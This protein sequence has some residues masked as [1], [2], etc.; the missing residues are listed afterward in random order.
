MRL[1]P[2]EVFFLIQVFKAIK[3]PQST[4]LATDH[5]FFCGILSFSS[6]I[7]LII[8]VVSNDPWVIYMFFIFKYLGILWIYYYFDL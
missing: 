2:S 4:V 1:L 5:R 7:F 6:K 3:F 8:L